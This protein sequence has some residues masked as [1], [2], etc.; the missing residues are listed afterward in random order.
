MTLEIDWKGHTWTVIGKY[1][2]PIRESRD[3]IEPPEP[4]W[5]EIYD[6]MDEDGN[7]ADFE[8]ERILSETALGNF[9]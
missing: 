8:T 5:F 1:H 3:R 2:K 9:Q 7:D 6:A 4:E